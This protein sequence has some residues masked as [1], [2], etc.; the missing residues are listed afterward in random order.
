MS[1]LERGTE[2]HAMS[3]PGCSAVSGLQLARRP[4]GP[5]TTHRVGPAWDGV[6]DTR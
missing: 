2:R 5:A 4:A 6:T 3:L 1:T